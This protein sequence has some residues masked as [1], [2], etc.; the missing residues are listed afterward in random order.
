VKELYNTDGHRKLMLTAAQNRLTA[1]TTYK[2]LKAHTD[3]YS[4]IDLLLN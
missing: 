4:K 2:A 3:T 1:Y